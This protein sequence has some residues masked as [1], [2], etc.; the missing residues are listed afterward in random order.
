MRFAKIGQ[1]IFEGHRKFDLPW[2]LESDEAIPDERVTGWAAR[3][4]DRGLQV[5]IGG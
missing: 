5:A 2:R 4:E 1:S 3:L